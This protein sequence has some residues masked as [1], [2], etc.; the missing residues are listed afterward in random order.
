M[1]RIIDNQKENDDGLRHLNMGDI[2]KECHD[3]ADDFKFHVGSGFFF[4]NGFGEVHNNINVD[5]LNLGDDDYLNKWSTKAPFLILMGKKT[6]FMSKNAL[7]DEETMVKHALN[8]FDEKYLSFLEDL[9]KKGL[10]KIKVFNESNFHVKIYFFY[11]GNELREIFTGSANFTSAGFSKNIELTAPIL[12]EWR[13]KQA[14]QLWFKN[15]WDRATD[16]LN[17]LEI[18]EN[19]KKSDFIYYSP[20][21]FFESL[22]KILGKEYLFYDSGLSNNSLLV[23][24]QSF[25]FYQVMNSLKKYN[26]CILASSVGLGKS[27]VALETIRYFEDRGMKI[28][29]IAPSNLVKG[30]DSTW[31]EYLSK[32]NLE[33]EKIGFGDLQQVDFKAKNYNGYDLVIIDEAHNLRNKNTIKRENIEK[34]I[35]NSPN[36]KY[37]L[38]TATPINVRISDLNNLI[39]LFYEVNKYDWADKEIKEKYDKFKKKVSKLEGSSGSEKEK[40]DLFKEIQEIQKIIEKELIVKSTRGVIKKYFKEDL[41][42]LSGSSEVYDPIINK[43]NFSYP[44]DIQSFFKTLPTF[45]EG[46]HYEHAKFFKKEDSYYYTEDFNLIYLYKWVLYKRAESSLF[47]LYSSLETLK[48][49]I[50]IYVEY[51]KNEKIGSLDN[52]LKERLDI[53]TKIFNDSDEELQEKI[54]THLE[55]DIIN[56]NAEMKKIENLKEGDFFRD[57]SK[58]KLLMEKLRENKEKKILIFTEYYD[59]LKYIF[60]NLEKENFKVD[61]IAGDDLDGNPMKPNKKEKIISRFKNDEFDILLSTDVLSEGFNIPEA[62]IVI[63]FDL[64]YNPVRIIQRIGRAT[65]INVPKEIEVMNF[66]PDKSIDYEIN[67]VEKLDLRISN[68]ISMIGIDYSIW[69]NTEKKLKERKKIDIINKS[70]ILQEIKD[71]LADEDP[72]NIYNFQ[73]NNE[74]LTDLLLKESIEKYDIDED[75][76]P[77]NNPSKPIYTNLV[78][79][80]HIF[81]IYK[82]KNDFYDYNQPEEKIIEP[83]SPTRK[84][85]AF[86]LKNEFYKE[87]KNQNKL[88]SW[89]LAGSGLDSRNEIQLLNKVDEIRKK[90]NYLTDS[91]NNLKRTRLYLDFEISDMIISELYPLLT[92]ND[93]SCL[94]IREDL[95]HFKEKFDEMISNDNQTYLDTKQNMDIKNK[96]AAFIQYNREEE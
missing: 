92:K 95:K 32:Y 94:R 49:K 93:F 79:N 69:K 84:Y 34:I 61:I 30:K 58:I 68:I 2:F 28:L 29:L 63:N 45:L 43:I 81:G 16:D 60:K 38:L 25:D 22:I 23:K 15:L 27:Y 48:N 83:T 41:I 50:K 53:A 40:D 26:G 13:D 31:E 70:E 44:K 14:H 72:E 90:C 56:I 65:R 74:S 55:E 89:N 54:I 66:H 64:P 57:D 88:L 19:Y 21:K 78:G 8:S 52:D 76:L 3:N 33:I 96:I 67:L 86:S 18:I 36:A 1:E 42:N 87:I 47:S 12:S 59:T 77:I 24:F 46:L 39:D 11:N 51:L 35:N 17:V 7:L 4:L 9:L 62:D 75:S 20:K 91:M 82:I 80:S 6:N 37:L 5:K 71:K 73:I 85:D 10:I